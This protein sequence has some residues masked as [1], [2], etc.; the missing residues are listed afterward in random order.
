MRHI[1]RNEE[2][3]GLFRKILS[4]KISLVSLLFI[5]GKTNDKMMKSE[6]D[7]SFFLT[8][9]ALRLCISLLKCYTIYDESLQTL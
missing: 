7:E 8:T 5:K 3:E 6:R 9:S 2:N 1:I 4:V